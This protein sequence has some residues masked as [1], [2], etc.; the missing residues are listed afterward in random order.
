MYNNFFHCWSS[1]KAIQKSY[2]E[3]MAY[4]VYPVKNRICSSIIS[5][6]NNSSGLYKKRIQFIKTLSQQTR[7]IDKIDLYG[8]NWTK[9]ELGNMYKGI[10]GGE[11]G[12]QA[13][14]IS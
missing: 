4:S 7:F 9:I 6:N 3:L 14:S 8:Y 10:L 5:K 11:M 13:I 12:G 1:I 2:D